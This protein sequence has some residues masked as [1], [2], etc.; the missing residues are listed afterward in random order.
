MFKVKRVKTYVI[1]RNFDLILKD[2]T[3]KVNKN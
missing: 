2:L 1:L 3:L